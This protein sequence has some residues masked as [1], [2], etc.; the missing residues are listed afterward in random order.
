M[1]EIVPDVVVTVIRICSRLLDAATDAIYP[2]SPEAADAL[3][4]QQIASIPREFDRVIKRQLEGKIKNDEQLSSEIEDA[5]FDYYRRLLRTSIVG[6]SDEAHEDFMARQLFGEQLQPQLEVMQAYELE[7][8]EAFLDTEDG[9]QAAVQMAASSAGQQGEPTAAAPPQELAQLALQQQRQE[10]LK[11]GVYRMREQA[12]VRQRQLDS[13]QAEL[14]T[15]R[16]RALTSMAQAARSATNAGLGVAL[17][18]LLFKGLALSATRLVK[19]VRRARKQ[20]L[21]GGPG[22]QG[23]GGRVMGRPKAASGSGAAPQ[24]PGGRGGRQQEASRQQQQQAPQTPARQQQQQGQ[25]QASGASGRGASSAAATPGSGSKQ[26]DGKKQQQQ[27]QQ[28][29]SS[30]EQS[31]ATARRARPTTRTR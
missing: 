17:G 28:Q 1:L 30:T 13:Q 5:S 7:H 19:L 24:A 2:L 14:T 4:V 8:P 12:G 20:L 22:A 29:Q 9:A 23:A 10:D 15:L 21:G 25:Q 31:P 26:A 6:G 18:V 27:Q 3:A 16:R 11:R